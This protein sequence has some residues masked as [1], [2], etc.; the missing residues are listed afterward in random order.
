MR[1]LY[2]RS[3][4]GDPRQAPELLRHRLYRQDD[5][6]VA[7]PRS[8]DVQVSGQVLSGL[9]LQL[10]QDH[11][12]TFEALEPLDARGQ[13]GSRLWFVGQ[14]EAVHASAAAQPAVRLARRREHHDVAERDPLFPH[15]ISEH[16]GEEVGQLLVVAI[17]QDL[18]WPSGWTL[19][20]RLA[21]ALLVFIFG[22]LDGSTVLPFGPLF[23]SVGP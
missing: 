14:S 17:T 5:E 21:L 10:G 23:R 16:H 11:H 7:S 1:P 12:G 4:T 13:D 20:R 18:G 6:M 19:R 15:Q 2:G 8:T 22:L 3:R 9:V